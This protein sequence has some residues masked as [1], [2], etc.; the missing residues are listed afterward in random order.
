MNRGL[1]RRRIFRCP[2]DYGSFLELMAQTCD[3]WP[4]EIHAFCLMS[5]HYHV[6]I[7]DERGDLSDVVKHLSGV[8]AQR[9]NRRHR[10]DGPL[11]RGRFHSRLVQ[12]E[13]YVVELVRYIH[14]NPVEAGMVATAAEYAWSSHRGY[15][16][17]ELRPRWLEVGHVAAS[18]GGASERARSAFDEFVREKGQ[19]D[20]AIQIADGDWLPILGSEEFV[21]EWRPKLRARGVQEPEE[22]PDGRRVVALP[23]E[24]IIAAACASVGLAR[25]QLLAASPGR[26][27]RNLQRMIALLACR[28]YSSATGAEIGDLFGVGR[29]SAYSMATKARRAIESERAAREMWEALVEGLEG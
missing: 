9:F 23:P 20:V 27:K 26:G 28:R 8:H 2:E 5:N 12:T 10:R 25:E 22:V 17:P 16:V 15:L 18:F 14:R 6:L 24:A 13:D 4:I 21:S 29:S 3:R 11:Y 19:S 7:R 1:A